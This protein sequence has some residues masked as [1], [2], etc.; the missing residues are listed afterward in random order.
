FVGY[1]DVENP[2]GTFNPISNT[3]IFLTHSDDGGR[4]WSN[5]TIVNADRSVLTGYTQ[6]NTSILPGDQFTGRTQFMP[7]ITVDQATGTL[8]LSWRDARDDAAGA[9]SAGQRVATYLTT[10]IDGGQTFGPQSY[11][12]PQVGVVDAITGKTNVL[13][14]KSDIQGGGD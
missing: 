4:T 9:N 12:N 7:E 10:S 1:L 8:V 5:P 11:A 6:A 14:P 13:S 2:V 3:D